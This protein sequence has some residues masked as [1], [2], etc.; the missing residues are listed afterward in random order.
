MTPISPWP[1]FRRLLETHNELAELGEMLEAGITVAFMLRA[2]EWKSSGRSILGKCYC[3]PS[4]QGDLRPLFEQLLTDTL[5]YYPDFLICL[6]AEWWEDAT[7]AQREVLLFHEA[8]HAGQAKDQFGSPKFNRD[9]GM[10][11]PCIVPHD[12]EEFNAVVRRY[13]AWT[14]DVAEFL[15][16][17]RE[18]EG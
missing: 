16:A 18:G 8:L 3:G 17:A 12:L 1:I 11:V 9:T 5:G 6:Q 4:A 15:A 2:G 10:P 7:D 13:G 14:F